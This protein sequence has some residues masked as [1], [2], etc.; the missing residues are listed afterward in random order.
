MK[1]ER[2]VSKVS[3]VSREEERLTI[4]S[5]VVL[6][7]RSTKKRE[8]RSARALEANKGG[9]GRSSPEA[10]LSLLIISKDLVLVHGSRELKKKEK[11]TSQ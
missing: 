10:D 6:V 3:K 4:S 11:M 8:A 7:G 5:V 2:L 1:D 9:K